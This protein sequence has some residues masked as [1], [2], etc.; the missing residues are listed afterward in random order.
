MKNSKRI[1][2]DIGLKY[3]ELKS[4]YEGIKRYVEE[5]ISWLEDK[6]HDT[7]TIDNTTE[8]CD[9]WQNAIEENEKIFYLYQKVIG[10]NE[11]LTIYHNEVDISENEGEL[12]IDMCFSSLEIEFKDVYDKYK[13]KL[14][15]L[16]FIKDI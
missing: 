4:Q 7:F 3:S 9:T 11:I 14:E 10:I 8:Y 12:F 2:F 5:M 1:Y 6:E 15:K 13:K 16:E